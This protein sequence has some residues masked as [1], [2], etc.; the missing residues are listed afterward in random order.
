MTGKYFGQP[1]KRLEDKFLLTGNA[2]FIDDIEL[3]GMLHAA[4]LRSDYAHAKIIKLDVTEARKRP[5]VV[6]V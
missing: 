4:F 2:K 1:V 6:A 5:G 3:P